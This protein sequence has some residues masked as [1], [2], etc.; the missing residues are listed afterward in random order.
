MGERARWPLR[1]ATQH[2]QTMTT[3]KRKFGTETN[4]VGAW[5]SIGHPTV[6]EVTATSGFDFVLIDTEHTTLSL[7][8]VEDMSRAVDAA[9]GDTKT[10]VRVPSD[11]PVRIKRVL[12]IGVAGIMVPS[13]ETATEARKIVQS[14][15]YPPEGIRGVA[16]GRAAAYGDDF[17]QY[18]E[19][20]SETITTVVQIETQTG[21]DNA[22]AIA[23]VD[24]IDAVFVGPADLSA[25]LG[26]FGEWENDRLDTAIDRVVSAG[27]SAEIPVGTLVVDPADIETRV[28]QEFDFLIVGKDTT[29]LSTANERIRERYEKEVSQQTAT[30]LSE[31]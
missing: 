17:Q 8:T 26:I 29:H 12:D 21:L 22:D 5:L 23:A 20:A 3:L 24:G 9:A 10:L 30:S 2:E 27:E 31:D 18:V 28:E 7:E 15:T 25:N 6:A 19:T 13:I 11:D 16:S 1:R 14:V 4:L